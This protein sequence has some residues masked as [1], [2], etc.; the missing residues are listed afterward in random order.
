MPPP[1]PRYGPVAGL[2][3]IPSRPVP[4][5]TSFA[6]GNPDILDLR[7][8]AQPFALVDPAEPVARPAVVG[9]HAL[10]IAGG[11]EL[12][13]AVA[14]VRLAGRAAEIPERL[15]LVMRGQYFGQ[16]LARAGDDIHHPARHVRGIEQLIEIRG[17]Q[18][19]A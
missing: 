14:L 17:G 11:G 1:Y 18:R 12:D 3:I 4:G 15:D 5:R 2:F 19:M 8:L 9:E 13:L 7:R 16:R 6:V 10:Q